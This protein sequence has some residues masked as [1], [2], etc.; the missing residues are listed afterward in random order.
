MTYKI[1]MDK[2]S[3]IRLIR[4]QK[5]EIKDLKREL[6]E[7]NQERDILLTEIGELQQQ[8]N[9]IWERGLDD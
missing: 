6:E 4:K 3:L 2:T 9:E 7:R 8:L 1:K 5:I